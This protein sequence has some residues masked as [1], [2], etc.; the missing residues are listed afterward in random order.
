MNSFAVAAVTND[1]KVRRLNKL[2]PDD[3]E[4]RG[5]RFTGLNPSGRGRRRNHPLASS[6]F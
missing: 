4:A 2:L 3:P 6:S 5:L 1:P